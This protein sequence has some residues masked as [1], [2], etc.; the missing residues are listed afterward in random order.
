MRTKP[1]PPKPIRSGPGLGSPG[2]KHFIVENARRKDYLDLTTCECRVARVID[3]VRYGTGDADLVASRSVIEVNQYFSLR[4]LYRGRDERW[5]L[6]QVQWFF[7][8]ERC[9]D[10]LIVPIAYQSVLGELRQLVSDDDCFALLRDWYVDGW[11]PRNDGFVQQWAEA[12]LS[13]DDC[14]FVIN[15][16]PLI[17]DAP[18][19]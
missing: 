19:K 11:L 16:F 12:T 3:G 4:Q 18:G 6:L 7:D 15:A 2:D 13:A 8:S 9:N 1:V 14:L 10:N 17:P 5:F